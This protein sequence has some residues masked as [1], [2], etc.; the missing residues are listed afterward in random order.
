MHATQ[1]ALQ[2]SQSQFEETFGAPKPEKDD[3]LVFYCMAGVRSE[4]AAKEFIKAG[5]TNVA[6]YQG[7]WLDW[8]S[9]KS[10]QEWVDWAK[11]RVRHVIQ[12]KSQIRLDYS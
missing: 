1:S 4:L 6:N 10:N 8:S 9:D 5:Y 2:L 11:V 3:E 7:G 12:L